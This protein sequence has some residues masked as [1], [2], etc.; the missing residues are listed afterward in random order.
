MGNKARGHDE[1]RTLAEYLIS[2]VDIAALGV[3]RGRLHLATFLALPA[4]P[5]E[6]DPVSSHDAQLRVL[7]PISC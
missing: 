4:L 2:D 7:L 1:V 6:L 5:R 3:S